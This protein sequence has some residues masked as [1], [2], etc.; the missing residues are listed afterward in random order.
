MYSPV[1]KETAVRTSAG[2]SARTSLKASRMVLPVSQVSSTR[3]TR[4][5]RMVAG[6]P[7]TSTGGAP[8]ARRV[9]VMELNSLWRIEATT[10]PGITPALATPSTI[11]G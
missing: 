1:L 10:T 5:P 9:T 8:S 4:R 2:Y 6:G 11:S 3:S 7:E